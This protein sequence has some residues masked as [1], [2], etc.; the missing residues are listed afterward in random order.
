MGNKQIENYKLPKLK[1]SG[2]VREYNSYSDFIKANVIFEHL[3]NNEKHRWLD[4]N[5]LNI[6][7]SKTNGR[8]SAN[9]LYYLGMKADYRGVFQNKKLKDVIRILESKSE[10]YSTVVSL[11]ML[12]NDGSVAYPVSYLKA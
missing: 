4:E 3:I 10:S 1:P 2:R 11:L 12:L 5:V 7:N 8:T 6:T 9:K